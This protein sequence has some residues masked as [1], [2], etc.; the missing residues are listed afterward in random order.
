MKNQISGIYKTTNKIN[1]KYYVGSSINIDKRWRSH[2]NRLNSNIHANKHLQNSW[3][4]YGEINFIFSILETISLDKLAETE[5]KYLDIAVNEQDKTYNLSFD[6]THKV[7]TEKTRIKIRN[8]LLGRTLSSKIKEKISKSIRGVNH[9][10]YGKSH[11]DETKSKISISGIERFKTNPPTLLG[12]KF[13]LSHRKNISKSLKGKRI[14]IGNHN[15]NKKI[16][17][18]INNSTAEIFVGTSHDF[19]TKYCINQSNIPSL[20]YGRRKSVS[21]WSLSIDSIT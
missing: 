21:G 4:K 3:L 2:K 12:K 13:T 7:I 5:Q 18:F 11:S 14:G 10:L 19:R 8:S 20:L 6:V 9:P 1:G 17:F 15:Y 16:Y